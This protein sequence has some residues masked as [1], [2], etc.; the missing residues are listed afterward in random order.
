M[1]LQYCYL[2]ST[3]ALLRD[4]LHDPLFAPRMAHSLPSI[5]ADIQL[6]LVMRFASV[7]KHMNY[8]QIKELQANLF[9]EVHGDVFFPLSEWYPKMK[10]IVF[11]KLMSD[12]ATFQLCL[13][14][15]GNGCPH[16][17]IFQ[18]ILS[19]TTG[20]KGSPKKK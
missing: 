11:K 13:F 1:G 18:W 12:R 14:F 2:L 6:D 20:K 7:V 19:H 16:H 17:P 15:M 3:N 5:Y 9:D 8:N 10:W 4:Y